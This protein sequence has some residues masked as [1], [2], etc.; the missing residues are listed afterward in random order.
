MTDGKWQQCKRL[1]IIVEAKPAR[2]LTEVM[3]K[4]GVAIAY[5][6]DW[7]VRYPTGDVYPYKREDFDERF[8]VL[9]GDLR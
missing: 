1:P 3:T 4:N 2:S 5:P 8:E 7:L 6:G 9:D